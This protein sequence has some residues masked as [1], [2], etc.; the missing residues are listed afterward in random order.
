M[1]GSQIY[2]VWHIHLYIHIK[3]HQFLLKFYKAIHTNIFN[4]KFINID[5]NHFLL[6]IPFSQILKFFLVLFCFFF[7]KFLRI[8]QYVLDY[9]N[10]PKY[11]EKSSLWAINHFTPSFPPMKPSSHFPLENLFTNSALIC[12][13]SSR[14]KHTTPIHHQRPTSEVGIFAPLWIL[15]TAGQCWLELLPSSNNIVCLRVSLQ[16]WSPVNSPTTVAHVSS[17]KI[18]LLLDIL[19]RLALLTYVK[20]GTKYLL[21]F[22]HKRPNSKHSWKQFIVSL[23]T[24]TRALCHCGRS[25]KAELEPA[26]PYRLSQCSLRTKSIT[27]I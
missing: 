17:E 9:N 14:I 2:L 10:N 11:Y 6:V 21:N 1:P 27:H 23:S 15:P 24:L 8:S 25:H 22:P 5:R 26:L 16:E 20:C 18:L 12:K 4:E 13:T 7:S 19:H 3:L